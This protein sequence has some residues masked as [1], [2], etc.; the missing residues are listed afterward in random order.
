MSYEIMNSED[1]E[2]LIKSMNEVKAYLKKEAEEKLFNEWLDVPKTCRKL[3]ICKRTLD[4]YRKHGKI[5]S[6]QF[7]RKI[8]FKL[9]DIEDFIMKGYK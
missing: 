8:M 4:Y 3:G 1:V 5:K 7:G 2:R 9:S 6:S